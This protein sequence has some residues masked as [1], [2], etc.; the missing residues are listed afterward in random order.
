[1]HPSCIFSSVKSCQSS[2]CHCRS[3]Y[4]CAPLGLGCELRLFQPVSLADAI[5]VVQTLPDK[6]RFSDPFPTWLL[7]ANVSLLAP[8]SCQLFNWSVHHGIVPLRIQKS[9]NVTLILKKADLDP[10]DPKSNRP[11]CNLSVPSKTLERLVSQQLV[12]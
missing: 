2:C 7:K 4:C 8:F 10:A 6:Q 3:A 9:V 12:A 5:R 1:M 11:I